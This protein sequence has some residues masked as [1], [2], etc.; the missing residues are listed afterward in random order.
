MGTRR[1]W[2][3]SDGTR[4]W[5]PPLGADMLDVSHQFALEHVAFVEM[6]DATEEQKRAALATFDK[7]YGFAREQLAGKFASDTDIALACQEGVRRA[8]ARDVDDETWQAELAA[9][10]LNRWPEPLP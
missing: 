9:V 5:A 2:R 6:P 7:V 4:H 10:D 1:I 8:L 3:A